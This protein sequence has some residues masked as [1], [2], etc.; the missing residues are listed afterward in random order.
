M[1]VQQKFVILTIV[2]LCSL[3]SLA[4]THSCELHDHKGYEN[5]CDQKIGSKLFALVSSFIN[6]LTALLSNKKCERDCEAEP[7]EYTVE[8][9]PAADY[10]TT[11]VQYKSLLRGLNENCCYELSSIYNNTLSGIKPNGACVILF[12]G[13]GCTGLNITIKPNISVECSKFID[14]D[15]RLSKP[16]AISFNDLTSSLRLC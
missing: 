4:T 7:F 5:T 1:K 16:G 14:C 11:Q 15:T 8:I 6:A 12:D 2:G 13:A 10:D 9:Y 3:I